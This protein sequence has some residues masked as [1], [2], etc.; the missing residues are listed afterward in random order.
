MLTIRVE[1]KN[2]V[3]NQKTFNFSIII[4]PSGLSIQPKVINLLMSSKGE[5]GDRGEK[6]EKGDRGDFEIGLG[7][8]SKSVYDINDDGI[9]DLAFRANYVNGGYF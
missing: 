6:G 8:M 3:V 4:P 7:D 1:P 5:K 2:V 9:V